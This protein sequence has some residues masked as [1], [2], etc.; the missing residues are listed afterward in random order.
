MSSLYKAYERAGVIVDL[1]ICLVH[2]KPWTDRKSSFEEV[3]LKTNSFLKC[4]AGLEKL[5]RGLLCLA[6]FS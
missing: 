6:D 4:R 3:L 5:P 1:F 2:A